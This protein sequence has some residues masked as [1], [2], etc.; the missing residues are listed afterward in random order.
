MVK[1][2]S[3]SFSR[4]KKKTSESKGD[5]S[6]EVIKLRRSPRSDKKYEV[7][8]EGKTVHFGAQGYSDYT[9]H[10][11]DRRQENYIRRHERRENWSKSG[12][13]TAGFWSRWLL[14]NKGSVEESARDIE[15]RFGVK[16]ERQ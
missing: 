3:R 7:R 5:G 1:R 12:L 4:N 9:K 8:V 13:S 16:I 11:D 6:N 15:R 14:W 10:H 2:R